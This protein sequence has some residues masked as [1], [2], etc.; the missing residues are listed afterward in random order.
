MNV[1]WIVE[2]EKQTKEFFVNFIIWV[3]WRMMFNVFIKLI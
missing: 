2:T 1:I 3:E